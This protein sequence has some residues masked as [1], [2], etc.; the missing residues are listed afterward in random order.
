MTLGYRRA[1]SYLSALVDEYGL[2]TLAERLQ[3]KTRAQPAHV[4]GRDDA[5]LEAVEARLDA[6]DASETVRAELLDEWSREH[7]DAYQRNIEH[8]N[9]LASSRP[10]SSQPGHRR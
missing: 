6:L 7:L 8:L 5:S 4:P 10:Q 1:R 2:P 9:V 3:P